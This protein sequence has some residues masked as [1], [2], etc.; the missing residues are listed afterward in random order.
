MERKTIGQFI[1][2]LRK[3]HGMTQK[4]LAQ[5]LMVSDKAVS[6]WERDETA[7]DIS[8]IPVIAE[9]FGVTSDEILRGEKIN[10]ENSA[11][12]EVNV[13]S[14]KRLNNLI[15]TAKTKFSIRSIIA[16]GVAVIGLIISMILNFGFYRARIGFFVGCILF[17]VAILLEIIFSIYAFSVSNSD[18]FSGE[19]IDSFKKHLILKCRN[20]VSAIL[21]IF[22]FTLPLIYLTN[23]A[24]CGIFFD[25][26]YI[27]G[28]ICSLVG[29]V[30]CT[31]TWLVIK[32]ILSKK[33]IFVLTEDEKIRFKIQ[34]KTILLASI[35]LAATVFVQVLF[36]GFVP[37]TAFSKGTTFT[38]MNEFIEYMETPK[39]EDEEYEQMSMNASATESFVNEIDDDNMYEE[40]GNDFDE[41]NENYD[42]YGN[43]Y[44][45][46]TIRI[47]GKDVVFVQRNLQ[48]IQFDYEF[49]EDCNVISA[50][51]YTKDD[52]YQGHYV[53]DI[54]NF[55]FIIAY[56]AE[57][58]FF[59]MKYFL[60]IKKLSK[61]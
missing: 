58:A 55:C 57:I 24:Y 21:C 18:E 9:I 50:T 4:E 60:K 15:N 23:D 56:P 59:I 41:Y 46:Q 43:E 37:F 2:A 31:L 32:L 49:D 38:D 13:K 3:A 1:S 7:P 5:M 34:K 42:S 27:Q 17:L 40:I 25:D 6:R 35:V 51:A 26:W 19:N 16:L 36:N 30:I 8:L 28:L 33:G 52:Y 10:S 47:K 20:T 45:K 12:N 53:V 54:I 29:A 61:R 22:A 39:A 48:V 14:E 44:V 11:Y